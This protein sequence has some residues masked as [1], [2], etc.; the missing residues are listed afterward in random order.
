MR[1]APLKLLS[2]GQLSGSEAP[3]PR[4]SKT[5][6]SRVPSAGASALAMN[7]PSGKRRLAG[8]AGQRED[9][10]LAL[11]WTPASLRSTLNEIVPEQGPSGGEW[12]GDRRAREAPAL[13]AH[14]GRTSARRPPGGRRELVSM[15]RQQ[16]SRE[17][18]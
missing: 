14:R 11:G 1:W 17:T 10:S 2:A 3:V 12:D 13:L 18:E 15:Q 6:R 7:S 9:G 5:S 16:R 4:W 8:A